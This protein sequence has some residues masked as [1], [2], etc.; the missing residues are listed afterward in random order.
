[1]RGRDDDDAPKEVGPVIGLD[2]KDPCIEAAEAGHLPDDCKDIRRPGDDEPPMNMMTGASAA[3]LGAAHPEADGDE[4]KRDM[5]AVGGT[6]VGGVVQGAVVTGAA[7]GKGGTGP[8]LSDPLLGPKPQQSPPPPIDLNG[9]DLDSVLNPGSQPF[10]LDKLFGPK[11]EQRQSQP[12]LPV[13]PVVPVL[14]GAGAGLRPATDYLFSGGN[15]TSDEPEDDPA[16]KFLPGDGND[17]FPAGTSEDDPFGTWK[18]GPPERVVTPD[19][20]CRAAACLAG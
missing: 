14:P 4:P 17:P 8:D 3:A 10:S 2:I 6:G 19:P 15:A 12:A 13:V 9:G 20:D 7:G 1:V 16:L 18:L 11:I 5:V